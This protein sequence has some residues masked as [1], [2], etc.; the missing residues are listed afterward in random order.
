MFAFNKKTGAFVK[1]TL[2]TLSGCALTCADDYSRK[3]DGTLD[4]EHGGETE[5]FWDGQETAESPGKGV[6]FVDADGAELTADQIELS[7][8]ENWEPDSASDPAPEQP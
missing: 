3:A 1:G 2:E 7:E 4:Y 6:I 8:D 5:V